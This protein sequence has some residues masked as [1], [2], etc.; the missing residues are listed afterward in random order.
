MGMLATVNQH[1]HLR[2]TDDYLLALA[3]YGQT[4]VRLMSGGGWH[5]DVDMNVTGKGVSFNI[6]TDFKRTSPL[7]AVS[8]CYQLMITA[9]KELDA[10]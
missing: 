5:A 10:I 2:S 7:D 4:S 8:T 1:A 6:A 9:L 3:Q